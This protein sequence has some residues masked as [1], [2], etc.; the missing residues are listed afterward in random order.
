MENSLEIVVIGDTL[1][2]EEKE[3]VREYI[4]YL[5]LGVLITELEKTWLNQED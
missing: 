5:E 3:K 4:N 2:E 1:T